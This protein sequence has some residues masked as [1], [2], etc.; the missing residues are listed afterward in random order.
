MRKKIIDLSRHQQ[1]FD[2]GKARAAGVD[3]VILRHAYGDK[4]DT[5]ALRWAADILAQ[6]MTLGGYGFATWHYKSRNNGSVDTARA[7][8][9]RQVDAWIAAAKQSGCNGWFAVDQEQEAGEVMSLDK[10]T[11]TALLNEACDR[12]A[13]AGLHPCMYCSVAWDFQYICTADLRYPYWMARYSDGNADFGE[14]GAEL[15]KLPDG[16]YTRWMQK[17]H[18]EGRLV[19]WQFASTGFGRK[20]GAGSAHIDRSVFYAEPIAPA[21]AAP[22][23]VVYLAA[24]VQGGPADAETAV[25]KIEKALGK[26]AVLWRAR[27]DGEEKKEDVW[28]WN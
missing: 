6:G 1:T 13:A 20:Y 27:P 9:R 5:Q 18:G 12:L 14:A 7:Q 16:Q 8:M 21:P 23:Q 4:P 19:G 11:N 2:A 10:K 3:G 26:D 15:T 22:C 28:E 24:V 25:H 17:L